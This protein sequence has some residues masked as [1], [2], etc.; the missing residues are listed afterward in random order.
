MLYTPLVCNTQ[1]VLVFDPINRLVNRSLL[2][3][4]EMLPPI[5]VSTA[6]IGP[7]RWTLG[8]STIC[9][10][11]GNSEAKPAS[12]L[13]DWQDGSDT[14]YLRS[15]TPNDLSGGDS[16]IDR[17]H[18]GGT[19][20]AVW[21][22]GE[23]AFCKVHAWREGLELE[24]NTIR[25]V[26]EMAPEVP[27]PE[28]IYSWID[29]D[30]SRTF[31]ITKRVKGQTLE[32]VWPRL[33]ARQ[34]I[35][36]AEGIARFC[37]ILAANTSSRFETVTK[38]GVYEARFMESPPPSHPTW[39]PR[40]LGPSHWGPS[41]RTWQASQPSLPPTSTRPFTSITRTLDQRTSSYQRTA[42]LSLEL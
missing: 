17:M 35:E 18:V 11:I 8:S 37:V 4:S 36:I 10:R 22:L 32:R 1:Y 3:D 20:A 27:V 7:H 41:G 16:E 30:L 42:T 28:I 33:S 21:C 6:R 34:R 40:I 25:F 13:I 14:F 12:A 26:E 31:L 38:C 23:N 19:S 9:E 15:R 29:H 2:C 5:T 24:A 39:L